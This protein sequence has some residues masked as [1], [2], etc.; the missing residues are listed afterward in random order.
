MFR[1]KDGKLSTKQSMIIMKSASIIADRCDLNATGG[2]CFSGPTKRE[3]ENT[4][5][6]KGSRLF[7]DRLEGGPFFED[8]PKGRHFFEDRPKV[9]TIPFKRQRNEKR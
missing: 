7:E 3:T 2:F 4:D 8:R 6:L 5:R 1:T 9:G